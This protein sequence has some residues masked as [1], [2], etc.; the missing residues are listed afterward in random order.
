MPPVPEYWADLIDWTHESNWTDASKPEQDHAAKDRAAGLTTITLQ[1]ARWKGIDWNPAP[2]KGKPVKPVKGFKLTLYELP[3]KT[4][5]QK[6]KVSLGEF[7]FQVAPPKA[8]GQ[9]MLIS[10][11]T[12]D[13][14]RYDNEA[15]PRTIPKGSTPDYDA[16][17]DQADFVLYL[18]GVRFYFRLQNPLREIDKSYE[19]GFKLEDDKGGK[20]EALDAETPFVPRA[21]W[22]DWIT[23]MRRLPGRFDCPGRAPQVPMDEVETRLDKETFELIEKKRKDASVEVDVDGLRFDA[24]LPAGKTRP[25]FIADYVKSSPYLKDV[26]GADGAQWKTNDI[27]KAYFVVH[28]VGVDGYMTEDRFYPPTHEGVQFRTKADG[29]GPVAVHGFVNWGGL[30]AASWDFEESRLGTVFEFSNKFARLINNYTISIE[31]THIYEELKGHDK[32]DKYTTAAQHKAEEDK[33]HAQNVE[34]AKKKKKALP[35]T[36]IGAQEFLCVGYRNHHKE[37]PKDSK[38]YVNYT[39]IYKWTRRMIESLAD[40][41]IIASARAGHLITITCHLEMDQALC[42]SVVYPEAVGKTRHYLRPGQNGHG[43][44]LATATA[45][46]ATWW[47]KAAFKAGKGGKTRTNPRDMHPDPTGFDMQVLYDVISERLSAVGGFKMPAG[48][49]YGVHPRRVTAAPKAGSNPPLCKALGNATYRLNTFP[50]QSYAGW[51]ELQ[52]DPPKANTRSEEQKMRDEIGVWV[53]DEN[54]YTK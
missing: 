11:A 21:K 49:R 8:A 19:I 22:R 1:I 3:S 30:Y 34:R 25:D 40:L 50:H 13:T 35:V 39:K 12:W 9:G 45:A 24:F 54:W 29:G 28:D 15:F 48:L 33:V 51:H 5:Q 43:T 23:R 6:E 38:K 14:L 52:P 4:D 44:P 17:R 47:T 37:V 2:P 46:Q 26:G 10:K 18:G 31:N 41:Y 32:E 42:W 36:N 20:F 27:K 16:Q 7:S 53:N